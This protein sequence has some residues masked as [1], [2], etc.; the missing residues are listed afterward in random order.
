MSKRIK[1]LILVYWLGILGGLFIALSGSPYASLLYHKIS[2]FSNYLFKF[3]V[4]HMFILSFLGLLIRK[5][6]NVIAG[7]KIQTAGYLHTLIGFSSALFRI[8]PD[9]FTMASFMIPLGSALTTSIIGWFVGGEIS[10]KYTSSPQKS[11]RFEMDRVAT[12]LSD[13]ANKLK[14]IHNEY[15]QTVKDAS[16]EYRKLHKKQLKFV[17]KGLELAK[18]LDTVITPIANSSTNFRDAIL[19]STEKIKNSF[20]GEFSKNV[21]EMKENAKKT[22]LELSNSADAAKDMAKYLKQTEELI[23]QLENLIEL[24]TEES[25]KYEA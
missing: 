1:L 9:S 24:I 12:E 23:K 11:V 21:S 17:D 10:E 14:D 2:D 15:V 25:K 4:G 7:T 6:E 5:P 16:Q 8:S 20:N 19:E 13:F 3:S 22:S 18:K